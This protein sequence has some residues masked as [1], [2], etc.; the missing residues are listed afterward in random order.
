LKFVKKKYFLIKT[1]NVDEYIRLVDKRLGGFDNSTIAGNIKLSKNELNV[2]ADVPEFSYD[3]KTFLNTHLESKGGL[4]SLLTTISV[5]D[6]GITDSLHL[7][8]S[9]LTIASKNDISDISL[10]TSA[11]KTISDAELNARIQTLNDGVIIHFFPSSFIINDKK[12]NLKKDGELTIRKSFVEANQVTFSQND[13]EIVFSTEMDELTDKTNVI[14]KL[15]RV[16]INDFTPFL[17]KDPRLEGILS[18]TIT[19]K[20]PFGKQQIEFDTEAENFVLDDKRI[21]KTSLKGDVNTQTGL[22]HFRS[23]ADE[24]DY[25]FDING[26]YNYKDSSDNQMGIAFTGNLWLMCNTNYLSFL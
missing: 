6:I 17:F 20:D 13:Q 10:K 11:S 4:D 21:G 8:G 3:G 23:K 25:K 15:K 7:P 12:W 24:S 26:T 5:S 16:N 2:N 19:L 18:G 14:A 9:K 22:I 1:K